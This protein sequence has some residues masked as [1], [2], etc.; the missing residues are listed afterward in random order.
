MT[1]T[2]WRSVVYLSDEREPLEREQRNLLG[3]QHGS[4]DYETQCVDSDS[5]TQTSNESATTSCTNS[6]TTLF[7]QP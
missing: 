6:R 5:V 7:I 3:K 2:G 4:N 1:P